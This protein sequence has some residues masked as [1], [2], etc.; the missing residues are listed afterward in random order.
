MEVYLLYCIEFVLSFVN[1]LA[2]YILTMCLC[3][4]AALMCEIKCFQTYLGSLVS[5]LTHTKSFR[6]TAFPLL[7]YFII[8]SDNTYEI[9]QFT[10]LI[11]IKLLVFSSWTINGVNKTYFPVSAINK[12][13][14]IPD[15]T[16]IFKTRSVYNSD[17][18][19]FTLIKSVNTTYLRRYAITGSINIAKL[20]CSS[21][22]EVSVLLNFY[23]ISITANINTIEKYVDISEKI[24]NLL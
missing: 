19:T 7:K 16:T 4:T 11:G 20:K 14:N 12:S 9:P 13:L 10:F 1:V 23:L 2:L 17:L 6:A 21:S 8:R 5:S 22:A 18:P 24:I 15:F 3:H